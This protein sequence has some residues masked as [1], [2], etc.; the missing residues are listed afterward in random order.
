MYIVRLDYVNGLH[1][2]YAF[3]DLGPAAAAHELATAAK[4]AKARGTITDDA[5]RKAG[6]EGANIQSVEL[7]D[8]QAEAI[9]AI[10]LVTEINAI[11]QQFGPPARR[12]PPPEP[13]IR[14]DAPEY[15][16]PVGRIGNFAS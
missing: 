16:P 7:V 1:K 10:K 9:S 12:Q 15:R 14:D 2:E 5:G 3:N 11:Q 4:D 8:T 13:E 6:F